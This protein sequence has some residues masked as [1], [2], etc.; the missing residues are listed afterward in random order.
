[1]RKRCDR[2]WEMG[3]IGVERLGAAADDLA[4]PELLRLENLDTDIRPWPAALEETHRSIEADAANSYLP[5]VGQEPLR[6]S[7]A[8]H[9]SRMSGVPYD[10]RRCCVIS[11]GGLNGILNV[12]LATLDPG[13]GVVLTSPVYAGLLN[14][15][16]LAGGVPR[17]AKLIPDV[18][19]GWRLDMDTFREAV[20]S[21]RVRAVLMVN[22]SMPTGCVLTAEE[23]KEIADAC[24]QSD[25]LLVYDAAMERILFDERQVIHPAS[26]PGMVDRTVTVGSASKEL[27]MIGW[28][29]GWI[30]GPE[31]L[32]PDI[33]LVSMANV[34]SQVGIGMSGVAAALEAPT[35]E[36]S[37]ATCEWQKRR[38]TVLRELDGLIP[39][40]PPHGGW[41][42]LVDAAALGMSGKEFSER[43]LLHAKVVATPMDGWGAPNASRYLRLVYA[44]E[45]CERLSTLRERV[46]RCF[47]LIGLSTH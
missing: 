40:I 7:V 33:T 16:R 21:S 41:S 23:W 18:S 19:R 17:L 46:Q 43:L 9:V 25:L 29:V 12:L 38:D 27:R 39:A 13:D 1:M 31:W 10:W 32:M 26:L 30:V 45:S 24:I 6:R 15:V 8:T 35:S 22:P 37:N 42:L 14:R 36:L 3:S 5:F 47:T 20:G 11:A 44:N 34:V 28:R 2:L 4:D